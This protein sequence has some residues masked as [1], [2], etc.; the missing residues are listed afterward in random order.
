MRP[1]FENV[2]AEGFVTVGEVQHEAVPGQ[3]SAQRPESET[4]AEV[5]AVLDE[6]RFLT[7]V[8]LQAELSAT[9][10][11]AVTTAERLR[12]ALAESDRVHSIGDVVFS[13]SSLVAGRVFTVPRNGH[14]DQSHNDDLAPLGGS[15]RRLP[16]PLDGVAVSAGERTVVT[17]GAVPT[18]IDESPGY[19]AIGCPED[20]QTAQFGAV[21]PDHFR[22]ATVA[23]D[24]L[25]SGEI[26][27]AALRAAIESVLPMGRGLSARHLIAYAMYLNDRCFRVPTLPV[28]DLLTAVGLEYRQGEWGRAGEVWSTAAEGYATVL[29]DELASD[30]RLDADQGT[31]FRAAAHAWVSWNEVRLQ[32]DPGAFIEFLR[33]GRVAAAFAEYWQPRTTTKLESWM[34]QRRLV[35]TLAKT[36]SGEPVVSYLRGMIDLRLGDGAT[37][38]EFFQMA[39]EA[40]REFLPAR[41]E[42]GTL[43][44]DVGSVPQAL[45]VLPGDSVLRGAVEAVLSAATADRAKAD[46]GDPCRC[47]SDKKYRSC[48]AKEL[49]LSDSDLTD[50]RDIRLH[51][52]LSVPPWTM[53]MDRLADIV[54]TECGLMSFPEALAEPIVQ[55]VLVVEGGGAGAYLAARRALLPPQEVSILSQFTPR[56]RKAFDVRVDGS[57]LELSHPD[58]S[59]HLR[60]PAHRVDGLI[61]GP[62]AFNGPE[63][64]FRPGDALL[65]RTVEIDGALLPSGPAIRIPA[66]HVSLLRVTI[67]SR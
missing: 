14:A 52:F 4:E 19:L 12:T 15:Q 3:G 67:G 56:R 37:A 10:G 22:V 38:M 1:K 27:A 49:H 26:E 13:S 40:D 61:A 5:I 34:A 64:A 43:I 42:L 35:E 30:Y 48:C 24:G 39:Y 63:T 6:R 54:S 28:S 8:Q 33:G 29:L 60:L 11:G 51:Q 55:D 44:L 59:V 32:L 58:S 16:T 17:V 50:L 65:V 9:G 20:L 62:G 21:Q 7:I 18:E 47:G 41:D 2:S 36:H 53:Q 45:E 57:Q 66:A 25:S 31:S 23:L 46:R